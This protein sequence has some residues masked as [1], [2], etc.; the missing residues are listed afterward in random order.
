MIGFQNTPV[1]EM[2]QV[3]LTLKNV[4]IMLQMRGCRKNKD[5]PDMEMTRRRGRYCQR[6]AVLDDTPW[7]RKRILHKGLIFNR[8][9]GF[10]NPGRH[11]R[12]SLRMIARERKLVQVVDERK[13]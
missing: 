6:K 10:G 13:V 8:K 9:R 3:R 1:D 4:P 2:T 7:R 12:N 5:L 11:C